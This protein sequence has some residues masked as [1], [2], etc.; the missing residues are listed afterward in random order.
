M[1]HLG[2][3]AR[4]VTQGLGDSTA[5]RIFPTY[6][7][8]FAVGV[9]AT[10]LGQD[11]ALAVQDIARVALAALHAVVAAVTFEPD[12]GAAR[13][14]QG[15]AALVVAVGGTA[16]GCDVQGEHEGCRL[17]PWRKLTSPTSSLRHRLPATFPWGAHKL[18]ALATRTARKPSGTGS[19]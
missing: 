6:L 2:H 10:I 11:A 14:A 15:H 12:G 8:I 19:C 7:I 16:D 18:H 3:A 17:A 13:L 5:R 1:S 4:D 9:A